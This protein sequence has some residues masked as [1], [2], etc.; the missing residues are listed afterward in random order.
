MRPPCTSGLPAPGAPA[1]SHHAPLPLVDL[2]LRIRRRAV[3]PCRPRFAAQPLRPGGGRGHQDFDLPR[4]R[5][6]DDAGSGRK[7]A[8]YETTY[9]AR[10]FPFFFYNEQ[11]RLWIEI[12]DDMLRQLERGEAIEFKGRGVRDDGVERRVEGKATPAD[13]LG[14][15]LKVRVFYSKRI[16]LIFN[17]TYRFAER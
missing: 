17:T 14:G 9:V 13:A 3:R 10:V 11:G 2:H 12:S 5:L 4:L 7:H 15:R 1:Q 6:P 8:V 16:E